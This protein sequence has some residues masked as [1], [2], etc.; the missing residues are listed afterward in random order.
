MGTSST[1]YALSSGHGR[2]GVAVVRVSGPGAGLAVDRMAAPRPAPRYAAF[3]RI[4]HPETTDLIDEALLLWLPG[5]RTETGEDMAEFQVHGSAAVIRALYGALAALPGFRLAEPG[6]FARRAFANGKLD[7][8]AAEGLADLIDAETEAQRRQA[9]VQAGG[10]LSRL[11]DGWRAR[12]IEARALL[13]AAIDFSDEADVAEGASRKGVQLAHEL[14][15]E[16]RAHLASANRGEIIREG[17]RV[18]IAGRPNAGK[19]SLLNALARRDA[20]IVSDEPGTT[21]DVVEVR[22]DLGGYPVILTDTAGVRET[23]APVEK[24]GIRRTLAKAREADLVLWLTAGDIAQDP[25]PEGL[26]GPLTP[27]WRVLSKVDSAPGH[28]HDGSPPS[29]LQVSSLTGYGLEALTSRI[30]EEVEARLGD[31]NSPPPSRQRHVLGLECCLLALT[32]VTAGD[33]TA[34]ELRAEDLRQAAEALGRIVG[35]IDPE[36]VL[37]AIFG[38]FCIGK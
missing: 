8:T 6:E 17:F 25:L 35:R 19:S 30:A 32:R 11:Y 23:T 24:E 10:A 36:E 3:R 2:A 28:L 21:R 4:R 33:E 16:I 18:V 38:R 29:P 20:A 31:P 13:E 1:I 22:L 37:G 15:A 7:L 26:A 9:L 34:L 27:V 14:A 12:L 5:P